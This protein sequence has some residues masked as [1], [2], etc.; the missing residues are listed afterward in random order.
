MLMAPSIVTPRICDTD[1]LCAVFCCTF[2]TTL[3]T[4]RFL[5]QSKDL[6]GFKIVF[7]PFVGFCVCLGFSNK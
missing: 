3:G 5:S 2:L 4:N 1:G 7:L 6:Y